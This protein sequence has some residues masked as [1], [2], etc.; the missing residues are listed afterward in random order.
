MERKTT[1]ALLDRAE[2]LH[3]GLLRLITRL[4]TFFLIALPLILAWTIHCLR[5]YRTLKTLPGF[6]LNPWNV[7]ALVLLVLAYCGMFAALVG[8]CIV[9]RRLRIVRRIFVWSCIWIPVVNY[10]LAWYVRGLAYQEIDHMVNKIQLEDV[11]AEQDICR[12]KY[13]LLLVHGVGF[14]DFRYFN[15][16]GRI[17][18]ELARNGAR[19]YYGHQEAWGTIEANAAMLKAKIE[20]IREE[21]QCDKVNIIAHSKGGLDARYLISGLH[22]GDYVA[23]LT[24]INTPHHGSALV[25]FLK[26]MPDWLYRSICERIDHYFMAIGDKDPDTYTASWQLSCAYAREFNEKY[27]N[28]DGV[29]YQS[30]TSL[31]KHGCSSWLLCIPYWILRRLDGPNDGLVTEESARWTNFHDVVVNR[32]MR[33]ISHADIIDLPR[34]DYRGFQV[35]EFYNQIVQELAR[36]GF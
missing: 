6:F 9:C 5:K 1:Q 7:L 13:P 16:W 19:V 2:R 11:R 18:R 10:F 35:L 33:G 8:L 22:M 20:E 27:P 25:D 31:M 34:E 14:R 26:R 4:L 32:Y 28:A 17:P 24:T 29:Y 3:L 21:N 12:T 30:Y 36:K 15:Y 23:S